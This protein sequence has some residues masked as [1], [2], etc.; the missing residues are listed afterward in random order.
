M[1]N[2][3]ADP[4][5]AE[6]INRCRKALEQL[7]NFPVKIT[8]QPAMHLDDVDPRVFLADCAEL[9]KLPVAKILSKDRSRPLLDIRQCIIYA[10]YT[11]STV[12]SKAVGQ[13]CNGMDHSSILHNC[14]K[15]RSL[16]FVRDK[17]VTS[18]MARIDAM[19]AQKY[20]QPVQP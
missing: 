12:G 14:N 10:L 6:H 19:I 2:L 3:C 5:A 13:V 15:I 4:E 20:Y 16:L 11:Y 1:P 18:T 9:F 8:V 7:Y 17:V